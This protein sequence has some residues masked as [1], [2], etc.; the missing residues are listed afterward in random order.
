VTSRKDVVVAGG[1]EDDGG[2]RSSPATT[3]PEDLQA[4]RDALWAIISVIPPDQVHTCGVMA[5]LLV[6]LCGVCV[7]SVVVVVVFVVVAVGHVVVFS[8]L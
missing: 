1:D 2:D 8:C 5:M 3:S 4:V 7:V 6:C